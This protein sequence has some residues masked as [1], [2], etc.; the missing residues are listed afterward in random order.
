MADLFSNYI[1]TSVKKVLDSPG[2]LTLRGDERDK[3]EKSL[4][5]HF[6]NMILETFMNRLT[7]NQV[8]EVQNTLSNPSILEEKFTEYAA[9]IPGL[10]QD[11]EDRLGREAEALKSLAS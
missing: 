7:D 10:A 9:Q 8:K 5:E 2:Y 1:E 6:E 3:L 11:I 4:S